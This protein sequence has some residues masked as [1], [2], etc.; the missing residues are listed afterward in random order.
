M[1]V[2]PSL[3]LKSWIK[4]KKRALVKDKGVEKTIRK[5][6]KRYIV[7]TL[8][9]IIELHHKIRLKKNIYNLFDFKLCSHEQKLCKPQIK[10]YK[11][12]FQKLKKISPKETVFVDDW[13]DAL[14]PAKKL[15]MKT[16]L[17]KNNKQLIRDL[18]RLGVK[19]KK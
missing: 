7:G 15:G 8:T 18:I 14:I 3:L 6:K 2:K 9:N 12:I 13:K 1:N 19:I 10:F 16:I 4:W 17:F 5:L 11:L